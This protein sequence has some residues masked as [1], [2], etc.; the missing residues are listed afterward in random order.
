M[1]LS[2]D[3]KKVVVAGFIKGNQ[4]MVNHRSVQQ[5]DELC[6]VASFTKRNQHIV[7][8]QKFATY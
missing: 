6:L 1:Q 2:D 7:K 3:K 4:H 5:S 8:P